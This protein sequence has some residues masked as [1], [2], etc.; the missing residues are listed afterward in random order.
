MIGKY[1][2]FNDFQSLSLL[3]DTCR[4]SLRCQSQIFDL[5]D[6]GEELELEKAI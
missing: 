5:V 3:V 1:Q 2:N 6:Y 4:C